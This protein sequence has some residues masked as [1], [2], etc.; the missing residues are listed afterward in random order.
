MSKA[1]VFIQV[2]GRPG[3][4]EAELP[5][6]ASADDIRKLLKEREIEVDHDMAI[7]VDDRDEEEKDHKGRIEGLKEG[8]RIHVTH[9]KKVKVK[10]NYLEKTGNRAFPPGTR[11]RAVKLW[12]VRE[13]KIN[14]TDAGEH[15]LQICNTTVQPPTDTPLVELIQAGSC[16]ICF[17]L[18]PEKR[19]EG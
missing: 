5:V 10:V 2:K 1:V 6:Q 18:V 9:C 16:D 11:V 15:V 12:A 4:V 3:I 7:F 14:P 8:S 19:V 13:F 17:D